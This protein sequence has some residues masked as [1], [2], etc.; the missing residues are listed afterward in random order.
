M[1]KLFI[2]SLFFITVVVF[3][4][5]I[6]P[7]EGY[8]FSPTFIALETHKC[9]LKIND[10]VATANGSAICSDGYSVR[11]TVYLQRYFNSSWTT[12]DSWSGD[13]DIYSFVNE[14]SAVSSGYKYRVK[15][16]ATVYDNNNNVIEAPV[17]YSDVVEN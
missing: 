6:N 11:I 9:S 16:V 7:V 5:S 4:A 13:K 3:T 1:K 2:L 10:N 8:E 12:I 15:S 14:T 17:L